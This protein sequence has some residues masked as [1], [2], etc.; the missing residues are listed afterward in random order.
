MAHFADWTGAFRPADKLEATID[1]PLCQ[2]MVFENRWHCLEV[3]EQR[4]EADL[5][6]LHPEDRYLHDVHDGGDGA[7]VGCMG[8]D[9]FLNGEDRPDPELG[10]Y[11]TFDDN[12]PQELPA[13]WLQAELEKFRRASVI[14]FPCREAA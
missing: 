5:A 10:L 11:D 1:P 7:Q 8:S 12:A 9:R 4:F 2:P 3:M 14:P 6:V 13:G